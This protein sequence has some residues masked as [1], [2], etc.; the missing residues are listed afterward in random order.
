MCFYHCVVVFHLCIPPAL[1]G[2]ASP[3]MSQWHQVPLRQSYSCCDPWGAQSNLR[4]LKINTWSLYFLQICPILVAMVLLL[5]SV[6][7]CS[8]KCFIYSLTI[9]L[10]QK[11]KEIWCFLRRNA[12]WAAWGYHGLWSSCL[13]PVWFCFWCRAPVPFYPCV[14]LFC[15][16]FIAF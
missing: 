16:D 1:C 11:T 14:C 8:W 3:L 5:G 15:W 9:Q 7:R 13:Q 4:R 12:L 6:A 10:F 2:A